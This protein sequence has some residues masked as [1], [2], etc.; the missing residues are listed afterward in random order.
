MSHTEL[1]LSADTVHEFAFC[2]ATLTGMRWSA[3][4]RD[5]M[6]DLGLGDGRASTLRCVWTIGVR[7]DLGP[8]GPGGPLS[9][10]CTWEQV[11]GRWRMSMDFAK[12]GAV[13]LDCQ[14]AVLVY[15]AD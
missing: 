1:Q 5:F 15:D 4:G 13:E 7:V 8:D 3:D 6:L 11:E 14:G 9:W 2:D 10:E 12:R